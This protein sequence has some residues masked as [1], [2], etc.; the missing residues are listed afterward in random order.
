MTK[1]E[2]KELLLYA[3]DRITKKSNETKQYPAGSETYERL[4]YCQGIRDACW[5]IDDMIR[6]I[7]GY[8]QLE[9]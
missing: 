7:E 8:E 9:Q 1:A 6:E 3:R 4:I 2:K 5:T